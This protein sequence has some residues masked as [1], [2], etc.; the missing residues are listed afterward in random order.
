MKKDKVKEIL[1]IV[2]QMEKVYIIIQMNH[3][4]KMI[5]FILNFHMIYIFYLHPN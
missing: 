2:E 4:Q 3:Y 1:K 5:I